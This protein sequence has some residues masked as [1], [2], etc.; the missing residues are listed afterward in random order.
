MNRRRF[1]TKRTFFG[2]MIPLVAALVIPDQRAAAMTVSTQAAALYRAGLAAKA[3][4]P[5]LALADFRAAVRLAPD[6]EPPLYEE[7][8]LLAVTNFAAAVPVLLHAAQVAPN[9]ATVWNI[10]GW[11]Y[12]KKGQFAVAERE[13]ARQLS[14]QKG[15]GPALWG[16]AN[17]YANSNVR[18]FAN[19]RADLL[20]LRGQPAYQSLANRLLAQLPPDAVDA[21]YHAS[22]AI[23]YEDAIAMILSWKSHALHYPVSPVYATNHVG[24][25]SDVA[26]YVSDAA[27]QGWFTH[28]SIP[29]FQAPATRLALALLLAHA[30]GIDKYDYIRPF[31]LSD[32]AVVPVNEQMYVNSI[33]ATRLMAVT[34][35]GHFSPDATVTRAAFARIVE[36]A[37]AIMAKPLTTSRLLTP[38]L[39]PPS[40]PPVVYFFATSTQDADLTAH[41][42]AITALGF[43]DYPLNTDLPSGAAAT[44]QSQAGTQ[45]VPAT[46]S[47]AAA[48]QLAQVQQSQIAAFMVLGN[49][50][51]V[52]HQS[53]PTIVN[54]V[55]GTS[56]MR[57]A[58][59]NEVVGIVVKEKLAGVTVDFEHMMPSD[60][61]AYV[62]FLRDLH[63]ALS[64]IGKK[65][66]VCLPESYESQGGAS[67]YDY[68]ALGQY[69][70]WVMLIT[71]DEHVPQGQPGAIATLSNTQRVVQYALQ[72]IPAS[73]ILLGMADFGYDWSQHS[74]VE[75]SMGQAQ[76]LAAQYHAVIHT[77]PISDTPT[78]DYTDAQGV[79]HVVWF[80]DD[81]SLA[82]VDGLVHLYGLAGVAVWHLGSE[83]SGFWNIVH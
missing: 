70:D 57:H 75:V 81:A 17:C 39:I 78:F 7:G 25:S 40:K 26:P 22:A 30:Y 83:D 77:D 10:L 82:A 74:G 42:Q 50:N 3:A 14:L 55:I 6:W 23:T 34:A 33:L 20:L 9:D 76:A 48:A 64:A 21:S 11:G 5:T 46:L 69:A 13:F 73:K 4:N 37:N 28:L 58:L 16:L 32:M 62:A 53:D 56:A 47:N 72:Q 8:V 60:R 49:Y 45:Y 67:A 43:T 36:R 80:E 19:A 51:N 44:G 29:S 68:Q 15:S 52:T 35:P 41:S 2:L 79:Q 12:Y 27:A 63:A 24:P 31:S 54:Q 61:M 18:A 66:M 65:T 1:T 38:P 71:Y 59:V